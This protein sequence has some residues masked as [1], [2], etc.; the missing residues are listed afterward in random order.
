[1][2]GTP[3]VVGVR[4]QD[5]GT[6]AF[7]VDDVSAFRANVLGKAVAAGVRITEIA[8]LDEDLESVFRY[9]VGR[10]S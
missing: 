7:D 3:G 4:L 5:E 1:M 8:P 9:L 10:R 6:L 2:I